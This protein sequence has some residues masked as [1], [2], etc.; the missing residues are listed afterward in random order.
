MA[1]QLKKA[2]E[3]PPFPG[4][5]SLG[6]PLGGTRKRGN[7][8]KRCQGSAQQGYS[9]SEGAGG[10]RRIATRL[11]PYLPGIQDAGVFFVFLFHHDD[12]TVFLLSYIVQTELWPA[13]HNKYGW[14]YGLLTVLLQVLHTPVLTSI[15]GHGF[16]SINSMT[17]QGDGAFSR[18]PRGCDLREASQEQARAP[19]PLRASPAA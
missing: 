10:M 1:E 17:T 13:C 4:V 3:A 9:W 7:W 12:F 19:Q 2:Q 18:I 11:K 8:S 5:G 16:F 14:C 6:F 15:Q